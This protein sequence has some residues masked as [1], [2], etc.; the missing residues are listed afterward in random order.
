MPANS[1]FMRVRAAGREQAR[2]GPLFALAHNR[3]HGGGEQALR[4]AH[5]LALLVA[6]SKRAARAGVRQ[7]APEAQAL[8]SVE[9]LLGLRIGQKHGAVVTHMNEVVGAERVSGFRNSL[10]GLAF[11]AQAEDDPR[12]DLRL[13][14]RS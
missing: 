12:C 8:E 11:G 5:V 14:V 13:G 10:G 6:L 2:H 9:S 3:R 7:V 1:P 4:S